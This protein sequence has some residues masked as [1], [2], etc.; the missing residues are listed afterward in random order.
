MTNRHANAG[1]KFCPSPS[2][3]RLPL[4][5]AMAEADVRL[6]T[7]SKDGAT[8]ASVIPPG[9]MSLNDGKAR[10]VDDAVALRRCASI[11]ISQARQQTAASIPCHRVAC[12]RPLWLASGRFLVSLMLWSLPSVEPL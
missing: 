12:V 11:T 8:M 4:V 7:V 1:L 2:Q 9:S 10:G 3:V 6:T 5:N